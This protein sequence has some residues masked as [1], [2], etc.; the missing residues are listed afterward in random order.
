MEG[1]MEPFG[2]SGK[3]WI[4]ETK[5]LSSVGCEH[6]V[7]CCWKLWDV[8]EHLIGRL[9]ADEVHGRS[10]GQRLLQGSRQWHLGTPVGQAGGWS[11]M[12]S[13]FY[14]HE[15]SLEQARRKWLGKGCPKMEV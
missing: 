8:I 15:R 11:K 12:A 3:V 4:I 10:E 7:Q 6:V 1:D 14:R 13:S 9:R 5:S 2:K